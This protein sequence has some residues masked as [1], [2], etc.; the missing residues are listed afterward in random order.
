MFKAKTAR[1]SLLKIATAADV[2]NRKIG[3]AVSWLMLVLVLL[4]C[5]D[6][7][8]RYLLESSKIWVMEL[9]T[10]IF[11]AIFLLAGA[12]TWQSNMHVRVDVFYQNWSEKRKK[13]VDLIGTLLFLMPWTWILMQ[14]GIRF[15]YQSWKIGESSAQS[16]GLPALYLIKGVMLLAFVMLFAQAVAQLIKNS[17]ALYQ[18]GKK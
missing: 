15:F 12:W 17:V 5:A 4:V 1:Q 14:V 18:M 11:S 3:E 7:T 6:V 2:F 9:E 8:M 10:Q 16:G 13:W